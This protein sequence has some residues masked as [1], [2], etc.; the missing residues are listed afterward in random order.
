MDPISATRTC[1]LFILSVALATTENQLL[2]TRTSPKA[3]SGLNLTT[4]SSNSDLK[5]NALT[6]FTEEEIR[7]TIRHDQALTSSTMA[8]PTGSTGYPQPSSTT[9]TPMSDG[10]TQRKSTSS[11]EP[12][13]STALE[14]QTT[15]NYTSTNITTHSSNTV[16]TSDRGQSTNKGFGLNNSEKTVTILFSLILGVLVVAL[17]VF[18]LFKCK[19][20]I[21]YMHQPLTNENDTLLMTYL[22]T[23]VLVEG[24]N[25]LYGLSVGHPIYDN[26]PPPPSD[27]SQFRLDF[28]H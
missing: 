7:S 22:S 8:E 17:I 27:Q 4:N 14:A 15:A 24:R 28:L 3:I 5:T 20:K 26:V 1:S 6:N 16:T 18:M 12:G 19:H 9:I 10:A 2:T 11:I 23:D 21:Q 25:T 13:T